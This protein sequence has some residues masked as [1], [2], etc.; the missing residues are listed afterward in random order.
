MSGGKP[1]I[2]LI[3][4]L[5]VHNLNLLHIDEEPHPPKFSHQNRNMRN[6]C[7]HHEPISES[8]LTILRV[9][10]SSMH[11]MEQSKLSQSIISSELASLLHQH[12][13]LLIEKAPGGVKMLMKNCT[14][15]LYGTK[16]VLL[17]RNGASRCGS[18][19]FIQCSER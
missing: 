15:S 17:E 8:R 7:P 9:L 16:L 3:V 13:L 5:Y 19:H 6:I 11:R 4:G 12:P 14:T 18:R 2:L 10:W 1:P